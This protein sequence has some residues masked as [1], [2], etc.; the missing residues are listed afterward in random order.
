MENKNAGIP[1]WAKILLIIGGLL[2]AGAVGGVAGGVAGHFTSRRV[3]RLT[4]RESLRTDISRILRE[5]VPS[6]NAR[7]TPGNTPE[8]LARRFS[9]ALVRKVEADSSAA[10][11]GLKSGDL[12][13][14]VDDRQVDVDNTLSQILDGY[15]AGDRVTLT[16][17]RGTEE[18]KVEVTLD[19]KDGK[20]YLGIFY[21]MLPIPPMQPH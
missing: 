12:V 14:A 6:P 9:G 3:A 13:I 8:T 19:S 20:A 11:A 21:T 17:Y 1:T 7:K 15:K 16:V 2:L 4:A 10:K 18:L 5:G